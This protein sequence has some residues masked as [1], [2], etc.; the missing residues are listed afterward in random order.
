MPGNWEV[1]GL[2]GNEL[3]ME[4][5]IEGLKKLQ[6]VPEFKVLDRRN[7][8]VVVSKGDSE[9]R[10]LVKN[11]IK[12]SHGFVESDAPLGRYDAKKAEI[13]RKKLKEYEEKRKK[14][15]QPAK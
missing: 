9:G 1:R 3:A 4:D 5:A 8:Q 15:L 11:I 2:F 13:K 14:A 6:K 7:L 10:E 12:I